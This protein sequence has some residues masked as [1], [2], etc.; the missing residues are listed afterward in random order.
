MKFVEGR[1][2]GVN[3]DY[4]LSADLSEKRTITRL[5]LIVGDTE[6]E[7]YSCPA[8]TSCVPYVYKYAKFNVFSDSRM[9]NEI[10]EGRFDLSATGN[11]NYIWISLQ[12]D[13]HWIY[14][15]GFYSPLTIKARCNWTSYQYTNGNWTPNIISN[16]LI[17][18]KR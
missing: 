15:D 11:G 4:P 14:C 18:L 12:L 7:V 6:E 5:Y 1:W 16:S 10:G 2:H 13:D 17:V 9:K 3:I 8:E